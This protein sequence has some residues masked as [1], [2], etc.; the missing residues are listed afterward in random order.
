MIKKTV[1]I[2]AL[3]HCPVGIDIESIIEY[4]DS[5]ANYTMNAQE[6][7]LINA[8]EN[9][10]VAFTCLWTMKEAVLKWKGCGIN[11]N[12]KDV[13]KGVTGIE[14][15]VNENKG[16]VYSLYMGKTSEGV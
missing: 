4:D 9:P 7:Q 13:L 11:D 8:A 14:T 5:L 15:V 1:V 16:Y 2:C 3:S 12:I 6:L 10:N